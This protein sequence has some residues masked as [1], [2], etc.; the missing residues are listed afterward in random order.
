MT[1]W[2]TT[3]VTCPACGESSSFKICSSIDISE[4]P[5]L[6]D[7]IF[8]RDL[9][10]FSCPEC[11]EEIMVAYNCTL[12]NQK[13]ASIVSL[14][15]SEDIASEESKLAVSGYSLRITRSINEFVEKLALLE[16]NID[17]K[18]VELY[19]IMLE[20]QFEDER[21]GVKILGIYYGGKNEEDDSILF[22]IIT[23]NAENCRATLSMQTYR[24]IES[25]FSSSSEKYLSDSE[26]NRDWAIKVLQT[27]L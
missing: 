16:D 2:N 15:A 12:K 8:N 6:L 19:K 14:I 1:Q 18:V 11:G 5:E 10:R 20:D 9:F 24:A 21:V 13:N 3:N 4:T 25:Q 7:K 23:E 27:G 26:I 17:D 22:Y